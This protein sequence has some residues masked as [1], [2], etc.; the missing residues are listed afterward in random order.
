MISNDMSQGCRLT[1]VSVFSPELSFEMQAHLESRFTLF[2]FFTHP[3]WTRVSS[4]L[5]AV[6]LTDWPSNISMPVIF[7][8]L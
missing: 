3:P 1:L 6:K 2:L 4:R 8:S 7:L 5:F